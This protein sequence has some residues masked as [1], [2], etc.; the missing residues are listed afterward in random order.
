MQQTFQ[1]YR[2]GA[3]NF[4][5]QAFC[6]NCNVRFQYYC[7][8]CNALVDATLW[9]CPNCRATLPWP[10]QQKTYYP[11]PGHDSNYPQSPVG[12]PYGEEKDKPAKKA[13]WIIAL[14][15]LVL[16]TVVTLMAVY[17]PGIFK[18]SAQPLP[19]AQPQFS[20]PTPPTAPTDNEF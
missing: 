20:Q 13:P 17:L 8:W 5:G 3:Q 18:Q 9:N 10:S 16:I 12:Y 14:V 4:Q 1:C 7:P 11:P 2:C 6:W 15:C 19:A